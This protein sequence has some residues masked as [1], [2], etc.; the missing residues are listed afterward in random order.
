MCSIAVRSSA[1]RAGAPGSAERRR[2][3]VRTAGAPGKAATR[4][5]VSLNGEGRWFNSGGYRGCVGDPGE[6]IDETL[7]SAS[8]EVARDVEDPAQRRLRPDPGR[9]DPQPHRRPTSSSRDGVVAEVGSGLRARD[10]ELVDATDTI[11]MP[12]FVDTHRHAWTSLFRNFGEGRVGGRDAGGW[13][14]DHFEPEDVYAATLIG[15]LGA[16]EAGITTVVDWSHDRADDG[17]EAAALQAHADAGLRTVY[18]THRHDSRPR[19]SASHRVRGATH[20][21]CVRDRPPRVRGSG[22][23]RPADGRSARQLGLRIHAH[24]GPGTRDRR[25]LRARRSGGS[26]GPTSRSCIAPGSTMP[27]STPSRRPEPRWR[28]RR[29]ARWRAACGSPPIQQLIDR[30][31]RPGLGGRRRAAHARATCSLRCGRRSRCSTPRSSTSSWPAR[32]A[33]P[34]C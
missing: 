13:S 6:R 27:T 25:D 1:P 12:G 21:R 34:T 16:A 15:L 24:A 8:A 33:F 9:E 31:I 32:A 28:S 17:F 10:A 18:V 22:S 20:Q 29:R 7:G 30:D 14:G 5:V 26:W 23:P 3:G 4:Y 11:V 2:C 19:G